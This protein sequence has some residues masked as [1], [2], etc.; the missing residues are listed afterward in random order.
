MRKGMLVGSLLS[1]VAMFAW[2]FLFWTTPLGKAT[3]AHGVDS[4]RAQE[5]LGQLFPADG[6]YFV[7]DRS[8]GE[9]QESW[10]GQHRRGPLAL[11][12][13]HRAGADPMQPIVFVN[14]FLHMLIT[15]VVIAWLLGKA[16][17]ALPSYGA[18][19]GFVLL[20]GFAAT[21]W[22][23]AGDPIWFFN[24]WKYHLMAMFYDLVAW[25]LAGLILARFVRP[26]P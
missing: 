14:G 19:V 23:H 1:A 15:C 24:P 20:A 10:I 9:S 26:E 3:L 5:A 6:A 18:R 2:G 8:E 17:P 21:F 25:G 16:V 4:E 12:F 7:P 11:V 13:I 22:G